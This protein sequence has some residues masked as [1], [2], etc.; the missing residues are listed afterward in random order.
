MLE[1]RSFA[2]IDT[3][4]SSEPSQ[5][6]CEVYFC[7]MVYRQPASAGSNFSYQ[8]QIVRVTRR[9]SVCVCVSLSSFYTLQYTSGRCISVGVR[10]LLSVVTR[11]FKH[12]P[13]LYQHSE[14]IQIPHSVLQV[15][16]AIFNSSCLVRASILCL[17]V[18]LC[19]IV[20]VN[21]FCDSTI[22]VDKVGRFWCILG[23]QQVIICRMLDI[24][25]FT[26]FITYL[27]VVVHEI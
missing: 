8:Q 25:L 22:G 19:D 18:R 16:P 6:L 1:A 7:A 3:T 2:Q 10:L 20:K 5:M 23:D 12:E 11:S 4:R 21:H 27:I 13:S 14:V 26:S 9:Y 17:F 24:I 15:V